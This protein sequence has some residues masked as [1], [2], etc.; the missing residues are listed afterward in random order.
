MLLKQIGSE[1]QWGLYTTGR[2]LR[3]RARWI[4][5]LLCAP[6]LPQN[7]DGK[8]FIHL[9]CGDIASP[10][11]VNVDARPAPHVHYVCDV[12][13]LSVFTDNS[14]DLVYACHVLEHVPHRALKGTLWE[15]KRVLKPGGVL[16]LSVPDFDK[17]VHIYQ[18]CGQDIKSILSCLMGG[19]E[20]KHNAHYSAFNH[21]Y[22]AERLRE[23]GF[24]EI[25]GWD[26]HTVEN[27]DFEDWASRHIERGDTPF[28]VSLNVEAVKGV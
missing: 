8:V 24:Q 2:R 1:V 25:R 16:R 7:P 4:E 14:A 19:Q 3:S 15:W 22:L 21:A 6:V 17:I 11:F 12:T 5:R 10:E 23:V 27:H 18:S 28:E 9:G 13:D 20:Y 26:P